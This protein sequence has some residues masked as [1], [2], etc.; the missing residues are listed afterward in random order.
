MAYH[1]ASGAAKAEH[2][3]HFTVINTAY[4]S[5][6]TAKNIYS[7]VVESHILQAFH[8]ILSEMADDT[9]RARYR[10]RQAPT[11]T[12]KTTSNTTIF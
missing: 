5:P 8:I 3:A 10:H 9:V 1:N 4:C 12:L 7:L 11:I 6:R 2:R